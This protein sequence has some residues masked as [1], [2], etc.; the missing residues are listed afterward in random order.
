MNDT[1]EAIDNAVTNV[2]ASWHLY[3]ELYEKVE[4]QKLMAECMGSMWDSLRMALADSVVLGIAKLTDPAVSGPPPKPRA[5]GTQQ[6]AIPDKTNLSLR[7]LLAE[8]KTQLP[9]GAYD[10]L[11]ARCEALVTS[12]AVILEHRNKRIAHADFK[13]ATDANKALPNFGSGEIESALEEIRSIMNEVNRGT[14]GHEVLYNHVIIG[15]AGRSLLL[16]IEM[17]NG[18][19]ELHFSVLKG[20]LDCDGIKKRLREIV[21]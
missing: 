14:G 11:L 4:S 17:A 5:A 8:T 12:A 6:V 19:N 7:H 3:K 20:E 2:H 15:E 9:P 1:V 13:A 16:A 18:V 21:P 10:N